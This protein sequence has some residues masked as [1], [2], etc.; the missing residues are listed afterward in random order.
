MAEKITPRQQD[1][2]SWYI[3]IVR[4]AQLADHS[5]VKGCMVIRP[6]G[7]ALWERIQAVLDQM[8]KDTGHENAYFPMLIPQSFLHKEAEHIEGFSPELAVVT[9]AGGQSL[10]E[11]LVLRPTSETMIWSM[12]GKWIQSYRDLPIKINQWANVIRWEKRTRFFLRSTEFLW[13]EGHTAHES[14][15][16]AQEEAL[17]L[18]KLYQTFMQDYLAIPVYVGI[19]TENEKFAGA[20]RTYSLE[21]MM[22]DKKAL[23]AGTSH[24]L[25]QNFAKA[26]DVTYQNRQGQ[27]EHVYATSWGVSTRLIGA[28][29]MTHSDDKGLVL[30]P[31]IAPTQIVIVPIFNK[32]NAQEV[33][34]KAKE[35]FSQLKKAGFRVELDQ[36]MD[37]TPGWRYAQWELLGVPLRLELGLKEIQSKEIRV[38]RRDSGEKKM[39]SRENLEE[40]L[41]AILEEIQ[42]SLFTRAKEFRDEH[43]YKELVTYEKFKE[44]CYSTEKMGFI[45]ASWCGD[46]ACE[47]KVKN[48]TKATIRCIPFDQPLSQQE[49]RCLLKHPQALILAVQPYREGYF[50]TWQLEGQKRILA[51]THEWQEERTLD[52]NSFL[53]PEPQEPNPF[54]DPLYYKQALSLSP[55]LAKQLHFNLT[56]LLKPREGDE[57]KPSD[58]FHALV[59][60]YWQYM[61]EIA[62]NLDKLNPALL[63]LMRFGVLSPKVL[64]SD[65]RNL[66]ARIRTDNDTGAPFHYVDEWIRLVAEDKV[67]A[68]AT[69]E[70]LSRKSTEVTHAELNQKLSKIQGQIEITEKIIQ[71]KQLNRASLETDLLEAV[72]KLSVHE[73]HQDF[74]SLQETYTDEQKRIFSQ[75][76]AYL[77]SLLTLNRD[78]A[79]LFS[80][81]K[82]QSREIEFTQDRYKVASEEGSLVTFNKNKAAREIESIINLARQT[83]GRRGNQLPI[84]LHNYF[85]YSELAIGTRERVIAS[86][87]QV[88]DIDPEIFW[89]SYKGNV[90]RI[91]PHFILV[92]SY[93]EYGMCWEPFERGNK[94][95]GKGRIALPIFGRDINL[96]VIRGLGDYRWEMAKELASFRWMEEGL[97]GWFYDWFEK[98]IKKGNIKQAFVEYYCVWI[99]KESKGVQ[100][101]PKELRD[102]FWRYI[103]FSQNLK[104]SLGEM[105]FVY[106]NLIQK[107]INRQTSQGY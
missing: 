67:Q 43:T 101:L 73:A 54:D 94:A 56:G 98:N 44:L 24:Y 16:E 78:I 107:D 6:R 50:V 55:T 48:D 59:R 105:S 49:E 71:E 38:A 41:K 75:I 31:R 96:A 86:V 15:N 90:S 91:V 79:L 95:T 51:Y 14:E 99:I 23:Q 27:L 4:E 32:K 57:R 89:R 39:V 45:L 61:A 10:E 102:I 12:F 84:L 53:E 66:L 104:E 106:K 52:K 7:Y 85:P 2:S 97:T 77:K 82:R 33:L 5:P 3:D 21:A 19:K 88:E 92:P 11:P 42:V 83:V 35:L 81:L 80:D 8:F 20:V 40:S 72:Q 18:L 70:P 29:I 47:L 25:G 87:A 103:P 64:T 30:P 60:T 9:H 100:K 58:Y 74:F 37:S 28:L 69:D 13:Q 36:D 22:Q 68:L 17:A 63:Y 1:Y 76:N 46:S 65:Q 34:D 26:F 93:G 62:K